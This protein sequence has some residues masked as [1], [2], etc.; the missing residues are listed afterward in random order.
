M[1]KEHKDTNYYIGFIGTLLASIILTPIY[2]I[3]ITFIRS[4]IVLFDILWDCLTFMPR[5][6]FE[7]DKAFQK[8]YWEREQKRIN[9]KIKKN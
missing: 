4:V 9:D 6:V 7:Y 8:Q 5:A 2:A 3:C 1:N